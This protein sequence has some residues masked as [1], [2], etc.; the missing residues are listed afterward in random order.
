M[1]KQDCV[2]PRVACHLSASFRLRGAQWALKVLRNKTPFLRAPN[3]P[4]RGKAFEGPRWPPPALSCPAGLTPGRALPTSGA[5]TLPPS[6]PTPPSSRASKRGPELPGELE[7][8]W[9]A[10]PPPGLG[11]PGGRGSAA[12]ACCLGGA[13]LGRGSGGGGLPVSGSGRGLVCQRLPP[14]A[15]PAAARRASRRR[16]PPSPR[17]GRLPAAQA[18]VRAVLTTSQVA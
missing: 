18:G 17:P 15:A 1:A 2:T 16:R 12:G 11:G 9:Q 13:G 10:A 5:L 6:P 8:H 4:V 7:K 14:L 3:I